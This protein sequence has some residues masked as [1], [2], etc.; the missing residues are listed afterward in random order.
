[1]G[2][3]SDFFNTTLALSASKKADE[4]IKKEIPIIVSLL[5]DITHYQENANYHNVLCGIAQ[6]LYAVTDEYMNNESHYLELLTMMVVNKIISEFGGLERVNRSGVLTPSGLERIKAVVITN[7]NDLP[8]N[9]LQVLR[10]CS[11]N[12]KATTSIIQH[13]M[14][15]D[16]PVSQPPPHIYFDKQPSTAK[17][18]KKG[19][20]IEAT[21][22]H[23]EHIR[24]V[25]V[26][27]WLIN[28]SCHGSLIS[29]TTGYIKFNCLNCDDKIYIE[30][31]EQLNN[32]ICK[33]CHKP[34]FLTC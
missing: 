13:K 31:G 24:N 4:I 22:T 18:L 30:A 33:S 3:I 16:E 6:R 32:I 21:C 9:Q 12:I 8:S 26:D 15:K 10:C 34:A 28:A 25:P 14:T 2:I 23:C 17:L 20:I 29:K 5:D 11:Y 7:V 1:M 19:K 27:K